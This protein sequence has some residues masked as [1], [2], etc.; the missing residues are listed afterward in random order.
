MAETVYLVEIGAQTW[1]NVFRNGVYTG[2]G[3]TSYISRT[4]TPINTAHNYAVKVYARDNGTTAPTGFLSASMY[5]AAGTYLGGFSLSL[6]LASADVWQ[7]F[8]VSFGPATANPHL[9]GTAYC[10][11]RFDLNVFHVTPDTQDI[12]QFLL[13][14]SASPGVALNA[15]PYL[16]TPA[17]WEKF[18]GSATPTLIAC[19]DIDGIP[20]VRTFR[21]SSRSYVTLVSDTPPLTQYEP[22]VLNPGLLRVELPAEGAGGLSTSFGEI[23]LSNAD[24]GLGMLAYAGLDGQPFVVLAGT[25]GAAY[26]SFTVV[27]AGTIQQALVDRDVA[28]LR[29]AGRDVLFDQPVVQTFYAGN[30]ALPNGLEGTSE[31]AGQPKPRLYGQARGLQPP[32]VNTTRLIYQVDSSGRNADVTAAWDAGVVLTRGADYANQ[33]AM[34]ATAPAA[35]NYRVWQ[36]GGC[37]RLG[38]APTGVVTCNADTTET[39][40]G[41]GHWWW[42]L[43]Y[44]MATDAGIAAGEIRQAIGASMAAPENWGGASWVSDTARVGVWVND[45][46]TTWRAA[47]DLVALSA[48]AWFGFTGPLPMGSAGLK[49]DS[50]VFPPAVTGLTSTALCNINSTNLLSARAMADPGEGHGVPVYSVALDYATQ[51]TVYTPSMA[52][53]V[54]PTALGDLAIE[55]KRV[56]SADTAIKAKH[57]TALAVT[58]GTG[59]ADTLA[60]VQYEARRLLEQWRYPKLWFELQVHIDAIRNQAHQPAPGGCIWL[61]WPE[62]KCLWQDGITR[63]YGIFVVMA[64]EASLGDSRVR[65]TVRQATEPSL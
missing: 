60:G 34:E 17:E 5:D 8:S 9:A 11:L 21:Y 42:Q 45:A 20:L 51:S 36:A 64:V 47:M 58:R 62:L 13:E 6:S 43:L 7:L 30:N 56:L 52:P 53:T 33:A 18:A 15:D 48:G 2:S 40:L 32:C 28:S 38:S 54:A 23:V 22:R 59:L 65:L 55:S 37:I 10:R 16:Y 41:P 35:G 29:I 4:A 49:F 3:F 14:D 27:L 26:S 57:G 63:N 12:K 1:P 19:S 50:Q 44:R 61:S 25:E 24:G 39:G 46:S 31:L